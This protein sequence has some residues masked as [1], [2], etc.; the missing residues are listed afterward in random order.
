MFSAEFWAKWIKYYDKI[1][2]PSIWATLRML[3]FTMVFAFILGFALAIALV[4]T[5]PGGL[6]P[7]KKI[8]KTLDFIVNMVRSFPIIILI[9]AISPFTR[10][11]VGTSIGEKAAI[12]PLTIAATPFL[13][14]ILENAMAEVDT[15]LIEAARSF[16]ASNFHIIFKVMV[17]EAIPSIVS[18]TT[19]ATIT[20][21]SCTTMAG[22]VGA[23]GLGAVALNYGYHSF[24][25]MVLYTGVIILCIM[26]QV[27]QSVGNWLYK[28]L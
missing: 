27:I 17:K 19:L 12:L 18:G 15:Q 20:Y 11:V 13:A 26:V 25:D 24:N 10:M 16:G 28:K 14:R 7:N 6:K 1:I 2:G 8:Y 23:G 21:L 5:R 22:A 3:L 9:V 4:V